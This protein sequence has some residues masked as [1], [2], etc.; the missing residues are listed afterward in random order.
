MNW[1]HSITPGAGLCRGFLLGLAL[2]LAAATFPASAQYFG[3]NK[4]PRTN[5]DWR[6]LQSEHFDLHFYPEERE[7]AEEA[8]LLSERAYARLSRILDHEI[9][10][11]IPLLL[12]GSLGEFRETRAA[13][14][15]IGEGTHGLTESL[16]RR[17]I[18]P[19]TGSYADFDHVLTHEIAHAFQ[20]DMLT[21]STFG[22]GV[23]PL[24]W[25]PPLWVMEGMSE[26][27]STPGIDAHTE[28]WT[29]TAVLEGDLIDLATLGRVGDIR[30]YRFGQ[31]VLGHI[32]RAYGDEAI[33]LWFRSMARRR[34]AN[35]GTEESLGITLERLSE[36]WS[37]SLRHRYL[38][39]L[40]EHDR[41][42]SIARRL[43]DHTETLSSFYAAP[44]ISPDGG[45]MIYISNETLYTDIY[46]ASA[47]DGGHARRI[48][49]GQRTED[50]ETLRYL[51]TSLSWSPDGDRIALV[52]RRGGREEMLVFNVRTE[53]V[54]RAL[55]FDLEEMLSPAWSPDGEHLIFVGLNEAR[56]N[57]YVSDLSGED[58]AA[59]TDDRWAA[60]QPAWS[61]DGRRIAFATDRGYETGT[62]DPHFSPWRIAILDLASGRVEVL[63]FQTGK[64]INPQWFP[65]GRHLLYVSDRT[66]I[67]NLFVRDLEDGHDYALTDFLNGVS[68]IMSTS[69]AVSLSADGHRVVFSA[70]QQ[71]GLD[72]FA[73]R[74]P[75]QLLADR[76]QW[77][78]PPEEVPDSLAI[79]ALEGDLATDVELLA[80]VVTAAPV[81]SDSTRAPDPPDAG[82]APIEPYW[83]VEG[84]S[85]VPRDYPAPTPLVPEP[86]VTPEV[87]L[88]AL[89]R[90]TEAMPES[91][92]YDEIPYKPHLTIDYA[93]AGGLYASGYGL[94]AQSVIVFSD[95]LGDKNVTIG[96]DV[97]GAL[98]EG[99]Y[100]LG[101]ENLGRRPSYGLR[102]YQYLTGY[103]YS[104]L[105]GYVETY[106]RRL[107][108]GLGASWIM[109]LSRF[110]RLELSLDVVQEERT[111]YRLPDEVETS[112]IDDWDE[113]HSR[114]NYLRPE[115]QWVFDSAIFGPTGPISGRRTNLSGYATFGGLESYGIG[116]DHRIYWNLRQRYA[117]VARAV[118]A[119]EWGSDRRKIIYGGPYSLRGFTD[120]P[121][122]GDQIAFTNLEFRFP[123]IEGLLIAWPIPM[124]FQGIRGALFWDMGAAWDDPTTFRATSTA[125]GFE[126]KDLK[127][128]FGFRISANLGLAILRWDLVRRS[129]LTHWEGKARGELSLGWE[130]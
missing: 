23:Q 64:N 42:E 92:A 89:Y 71:A 120:H 6:I 47:L 73:I 119:G 127:A 117:F 28:M 108:R 121:L 123:F 112:F 107:M 12:Y 103:G 15:L 78:P 19:F 96:V 74:E 87:D 81:V 35:R 114:S 88:P 46:L 36:D 79:A 5:H 83:R 77:T 39:E 40:V 102:A 56:S 128:S 110:R 129:Q 66:G 70:Y 30:V 48:I 2:G 1:D 25:A 3:Q 115:V 93:S 80:A 55:T 97:N 32:A 22:R 27:L 58:F 8:L 101:Y 98:D 105:P 62:F 124:L 45:E 52:T 91:L 20:I 84:E 37:D 60:F 11:R 76:S 10:E 113:E 126:L 24:S 17:V 7:A 99:N 106:E 16:K 51:R 49:R 44:A 68:G 82:D 122:Y 13:S 34:D 125:N 43:T 75:L 54:E 85:Q 29:R 95:M 100:L 21:R 18:V 86:V 61:P 57:L 59:V 65:D 67:S 109:P 90:E 104:I 26:Y 63:P 31:S 38:P 4:V 130:F 9:P 94:S 50:F 116:I 118:V 14:G 111:S 69:S 72:L 33:G 41:I 53:E